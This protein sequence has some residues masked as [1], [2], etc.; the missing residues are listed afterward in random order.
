[1][2]RLSRVLPRPSRELEGAGIPCAG[3]PTQGTRSPCPHEVIIPCACWCDVTL[4]PLNI[5]AVAERSQEFYRNP[6]QSNRSALCQP[7]PLCAPV[8]RTW[9][10]R[11]SLG[12]SPSSAVCCCAASGTVPNLP[13]PPRMGLGDCTS[14]THIVALLCG[15]HWGGSPSPPC[16]RSG[17]PSMDA[18]RLS[19]GVPPNALHTEQNLASP[20]RLGFCQKLAHPW[21]GQLCLPVCHGPRPRGRDPAP[22]SCAPRGLTGSRTQRWPRV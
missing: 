14:S 12:W 20:W 18:G 5:G 6:K 11:E 13:A 7:R 1:M 4:S 3:R 17:T 22:V 21:C 2:G 9:C 15:G 19:L 8:G 10:R 16:S